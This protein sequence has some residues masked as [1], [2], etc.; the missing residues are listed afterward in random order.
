MLNARPLIFPATTEGAAARDAYVTWSN[1]NAGIGMPDPSS[2]R[3]FQVTDDRRDAYGQPWCVM[4]EHLPSWT[5]PEGGAAMRTAGVI[6]DSIVHP[7]V[8]EI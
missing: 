1:L 3:P 7:D 2:W 5:E 6:H 4:C 8:G